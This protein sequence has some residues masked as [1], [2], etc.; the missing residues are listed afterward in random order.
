VTDRRP[1]THHE[2]L[3]L[4]EP[5][6]RR[7]RHVDLAASDRIERRLLFKPVAHE[8][9]GAV[10]TL[11]LEDLRRNVWR[12]VRSVAL[13]TGETARLTAEGDD[14]GA[15]LARIDN[16]PLHIHFR[17]IGAVTLVRSYRLEVESKTGAV[18]QILAGAEARLDG[19]TFFVKTSA[20]KGYPAEIELS[21][22]A[23]PPDDLPEDLLAAL[24][25][26]WRLLRRRGASWVGTLRAPGRE[27]ERSRRLEALLETAVAHLA[28]TLAEP[29]R[30]FHEKFVRARWG[31]ALRRMIPLLGAAGLFAGALAMVYIDL[32]PNSPLALMMFNAPPILLALLFTMQEMPKLEVPPPPRPSAAP[33][34]FPAPAQNA[35]PGPED[36]GGGDNVQNP[37]TVADRREVLTGKV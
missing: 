13:T 2:I 15:L 34:W 36:G 31:V 22:Q 4:V 30:V 11:S 35:G 33:S 9:L 26:D 25:R 16:A 20:A 5:F 37:E 21:P 14:P 18:V 29:P 12:L 6:T 10:E 28:Q 19:L 1:L 7:G 17:R 8:D 23:D 3:A 27:P 32:P 24:G